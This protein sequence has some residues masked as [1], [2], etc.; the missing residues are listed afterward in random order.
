VRDRFPPWI[1]VLLRDHLVHSRRE[2]NSAPHSGSTRGEA[3]LR[4]PR[5]SRNKTADSATSCAPDEDYLLQV[6]SQEF[7]CPINPI[8]HFTHKGVDTDYKKEGSKRFWN[9]APPSRL[10]G[11]FALKEGRKEIHHCS[12]SFL[13]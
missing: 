3:F 8:V 6:K 7:T 10:S 11:T 12:N 2:G 9:G 5:E 13:P 1:H 4:N